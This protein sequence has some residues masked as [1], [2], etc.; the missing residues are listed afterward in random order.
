MRC[1][2]LLAILT[3]LRLPAQDPKPVVAKLDA[4]KD[5][6]QIGTRDVSKGVNFYSIEKEM[7][8]GKGLSQQMEKRSTLVQDKLIAEYVNRLAQNLARHSDAKIP[9][10]VKVIEGDDPDAVTIP[11]GYIYV[12]T[13]L[14]RA[15]DTEA[16]LAAA[17]AHEIAHVAARHG[18]R[19]ATQSQIGQVA[20]I[21]LI[22]LGGGLGTLCMSA[23]EAAAVPAGTLAIQRGYEMEA[24]MLGLQYLYK[25][26][27]D[28]LSMVDIFEKIFSIAEQKHPKLLAR[29]ASTHPTGENR[30]VTVQKNI[31]TLLKARPEYIVNTSEFDNMKVRLL[32]LDWA[33][34]P[35]PEEPK[36]PSLRLP[37]DQ[38]IASKKAVPESDVR[39]SQIKEAY[40]IR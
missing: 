38:L 29:L 20:A 22:F 31:E 23:A 11:G 5:P 33:R 30:L 34:K 12:H 17:L 7:A 40:T 32:A 8:V 3:S 16:E 39:A 36:R 28:P 19:Q 2:F 1:V 25:S 21:P 4:K 9:I 26:G 13:G 10:T 6:D 37:G 18:T 24:D 14:I 15:A 27:Y 35:A